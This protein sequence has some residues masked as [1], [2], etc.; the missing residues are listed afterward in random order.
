M[1]IEGG[2]YICTSEDIKEKLYFGT[3]Q[4]TYTTYDKFDSLS[5]GQ[6]ITFPA[7]MS[8]SNGNWD[9]GKEW[10][11]GLN[12]E[13]QSSGITD[14]PMPLDYSIVEDLEFIEF[15]LYFKVI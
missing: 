3:N 7:P 1:H 13:N 4:I 5:D 8:F 11:I 12:F 9:I 2:P 15:D 14:P 6:V 10:W